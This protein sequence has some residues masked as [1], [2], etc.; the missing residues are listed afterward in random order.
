MYITAQKLRSKDG[1]IGRNS[2]LYEHSEADGR[3]FEDRNPDVVDIAERHLGRL[4]AQS[5]DLPPGGNRVLSYLDVAAVDGTNLKNIEAALKAVA[6]QI[7]VGL[8]PIELSLNGVSVRFCWG[9]CM[10]PSGVTVV[11]DEFDG[12]CKK[13][14][15]IF[16]TERSATNLTLHPLTVHV[17]FDENGYGF[18]MAPNSI[19]RIREAHRDEEWTP[20]PINVGYDIML[21]FQAIHGDLIPHLVSALVDL[22]LEEVISMGGVSLLGPDGREIRRWPRA[23]GLQD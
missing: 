6:S 23:Q 8:S 17:S 9:Q 13:V 14:L 5:Y 18:R 1:Q 19:K 2:F 10:G 22:R 12:L 20:A 3:L 21:D 4:A 7:T 16:H 11:R 15:E